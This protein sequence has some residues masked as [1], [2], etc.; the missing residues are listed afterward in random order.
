METRTVAVWAVLTVAASGQQTVV[1]W[2]LPK[3]A[4]WAALTVA[5]VQ[6][7]SACSSGSRRIPASQSRT[8]RAQS[9]TPAGSTRQTLRSTLGMR[10]RCRNPSSS[11]RPPSEP[12]AAAMEMRTVAAWAVGVAMD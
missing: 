10:Q 4:A 11:P 3:V 5:E 2:A 6:T 7:C 8:L 12:Q 9:G 1:A